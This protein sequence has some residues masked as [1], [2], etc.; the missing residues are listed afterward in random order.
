[1]ITN[2]PRLFDASKVGM[3]ANATGRDLHIDGLLSNLSIGYRP[4]GMI[5]DQIFPI[6]TVNKQSDGYPIWSRAD[7]LRTENAVRAPKT[8]ANRINASVSTDTYFA[9]NFAL[10]IETSWEDLANADEAFGLR[11]TN[12]NLVIDNLGLNAEVRIAARV[13]NTANV[14]SSNA[15]AANYGN[16]GAT[17]PIDDLDA[18]IESVRTQTG[19]RPNK[20]VFGPL[21]WMRF[22]KHA[23]VIDF[24][25]GKG[26]NVGGGGV[27][28]AQVAAAWQF[29]SVL[30]G[31]AIQNTAQEGAAATMSDVWSNHIALLHVAARPNRMTPSFGYT[32]QWRPG[33]FP[34][35]FT[36]RRYDEEPEMIEVQEVHHFQDEKVTGTELGFLII[37]G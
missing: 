6:V 3:Y 11:E 26:D 24:I 17:T 27:T 31:N 15:L 34:A 5:W 13:C 36:V 10:G 16:V 28:E 14:G 12:T 37:G 2:D 4:T 25:R 8:R 7:L 19:L 1:M 23:D 30:V 9:K 22:R 18:G 33:G 21:T 29:Q 20:A 35:P 32:F